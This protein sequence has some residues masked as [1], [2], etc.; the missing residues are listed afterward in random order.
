M[1]G[2]AL[3]KEAFLYVHD[4]LATVEE[5][6]KWVDNLIRLPN[7]SFYIQ[8]ADAEFSHTKRIEQKFADYH[9]LVVLPV[10][11]FRLPTNAPQV[12]RFYL[13]IIR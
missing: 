11:L 6:V 8:V 13:E 7:V 9:R 1:K 2:N 3:T 10:P 5:S 4:I 12:Y